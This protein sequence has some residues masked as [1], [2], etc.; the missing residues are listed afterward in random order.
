V[1]NKKEEK[2]VDSKVAD[3]KPEKKMTVKDFKI[4]A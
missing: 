1:V 2:K 4:L 3:I